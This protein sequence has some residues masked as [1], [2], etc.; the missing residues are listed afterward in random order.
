[1]A[2]F[3]ARPLLDLLRN[4]RGPPAPQRYSGGPRTA[5]CITLVTPRPSEGQVQSLHTELRRAPLLRPMPVDRKAIPG[6]GDPLENVDVDRWAQTE[7]LRLVFSNLPVTLAA[8]VASVC[9]SAAILRHA[10]RP[11]TLLA[12]VVAGIVI[13]CLR[14]LDYRQ[15]RRSEASLLDVRRWGRRLMLGTG[16]SGIFWGSAA[17][18]LFPPDDLPHQIVIAFI[19]AGMGAGGMTSYSAIRRCYFAFVLP[20]VVPIAIRM[21]LQPNE[22][23]R[24]MALLTVLFLGVVI[25]S[26]SETDRTIG[27]VL[28]TRAENARLLQELHHQA[29]HDSL[30]DL[31]NQREFHARLLSLSQSSARER[32]PYAL[33]FIDLDRF[34][35]INDTAGHAAGDAALR[36]VADLLRGQV[37]TGDTAA[38]LG[39]D[40]FAVL[41]PDAPRDAAEGVAQRILAAI[42]QVAL[43]WGEKRFSIGASIGLAYSES[44]ECDA[45]AL[46]RA[47]DAACYAAKTSGRSRLEIY[48]AT[49][50][51]EPSGRFE[52]SSLRESLT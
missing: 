13:S 52:I 22:I 6:T 5:N 49:S 20:A 45:T 41:L 16:A 14:Y 32:K 26:A 10:A 43:R 31:P 34:K 30:V 50:E 37:R 27:N 47:A 42:D 29:T 48:C 38:R 17:L 2:S 46:M 19:L 39:G 23:D 25:R 21:A 1:M 51:Y 7:R 4:P 33:L 11:L 35:D 3:A 18:A 24:G 44:G 8:S 36:H 28:L 12:W 9:I 40:E 15:F